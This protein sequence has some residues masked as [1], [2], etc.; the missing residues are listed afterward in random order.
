MASFDE[1]LDHA[2]ELL[3]QLD[4][5]DRRD[6]EAALGKLG[7]AVDLLDAHVQAAF[8]EADVGE[9][10]ETRRLQEQLTE[11]H[12]H[13]D[14]MKAARGEQRAAHRRALGETFAHLKQ[15]WRHVRE[16]ASIGGR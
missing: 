15:S 4:A 3:G 9:G 5:A 12:T 1:R 7:A 13:Y 2:Q 16:H 14:L 8:S 11:A 6:H 10:P